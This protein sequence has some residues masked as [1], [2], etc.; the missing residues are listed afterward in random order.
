MW[1]ALFFPL[2]FDE[3]AHDLGMERDK[4]RRDNVIHHLTSSILLYLNRRRVFHSGTTPNLW[5][6][7][8]LRP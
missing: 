3:V 5:T 2:G 7:T 6:G 4:S 8:F 1:T